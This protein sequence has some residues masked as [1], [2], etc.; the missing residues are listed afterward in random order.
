MQF[1]RRSN[2]VVNS[3]KD[4]AGINNQKKCRPIGRN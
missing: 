1:D 3:R 4:Y 2:D